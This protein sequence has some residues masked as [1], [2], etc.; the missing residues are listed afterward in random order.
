[1]RRIA[2]PAA[3]VLAGLILFFLLRG[4][5]APAPATPPSVAVQTMTL[6]KTTVPRIVE[7]YGSVVGGPAQRDI[8]L[9][10]AGIVNRVMVVPGERVAEGERL[11]RIVP[12]ADSVATLHKAEDAVKAAEAARAHVSALL[13]AHLATQADLAA[14][15]QVLNDAQAQLAALRQNGAGT[16]RDITAPVAGVV[17]AVLAA[18]GSAQAAGA[19]LFRLVDAAHPAALVGVPEGEAQGILSGTHATLSLLVSNTTI[20]AVVAHRAAMLDPQTG[21]IDITLALNGSA[22]IGE[23]VRAALRA[24]T[25]TGYA[26]PRDAV[27][28]D[29]YGNY[30]FQEGRDG[31]A[32][33]AN[34]RV[35]GQLGDKTILAPTL[36]TALPLITTGAYQL[37][38]GMAVREAGQN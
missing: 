35:L 38:D 4:G 24:G 31:L 14:A 10:A 19:P 20:Q 37:S 13:A 9:P 7:A 2:I 1:M 6:T 29:E 25:L 8:I 27:Q 22:P 17:T 26:V 32:H 36:N 5:S 16:T 28:N 15:D 12:D 18:Q 11:A 23:S 3:F 21:L 33:R 34:V 30:V